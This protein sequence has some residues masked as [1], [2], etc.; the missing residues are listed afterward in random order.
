MDY[1]LKRHPRS[2]SLRVIVHQDGEVV[3]TAPMRLPKV[4]I[5]RFVTQK[6][7]WILEARQRVARRP[8]STLPMAS[9]GDYQ[10]YRS[11]ALRLVTARLAYFNQQYGFTWKTIS[12]RN[13]RTRWGSCSSTGRLSFSY[14]LALLPPE[15]ADYIVVHELCH[16]GE[17]NHSLKFWALV[18]KTMP[19]YRQLK[20]RLRYG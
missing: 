15:L 11:Q 16:L 2:R 1:T 8:V 13:Q 10:K 12:I 18:A 17:M 14:R 3:V 4:L 9:V 19:E 20:T 5:D 6:Q 7:T